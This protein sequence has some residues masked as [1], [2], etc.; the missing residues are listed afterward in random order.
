M[1]LHLLWP[2]YE[3]GQ[4]V[5]FLPCGF[6]L[7]SIFFSSLNLSGRRLDVYHTLTHDVALVQITN[8]CLKCAA[9]ASW[10]IQDAKIMQK[11]S[12]LCP[13]ISFLS[14]LWPPYVIGA[15]I[16]IFAL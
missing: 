1:T 15:E 7:L 5:I 12:Q 4:A 8:A 16:Y 14:Y 11:S 9:H 13:A 3:I 10:E 2:P 6:F